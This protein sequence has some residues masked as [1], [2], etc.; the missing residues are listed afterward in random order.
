VIPVNDA[1]HPPSVLSNREDVARWFDDSEGLVLGLDFD[2]TLAPIVDDPTESAIT[3]RARELLGK[4]AAH[5]R[6]LVAVVSGRELDDLV[7]RVGIEGPVYAGNHGLELRV[8][9]ETL[10]HPEAARQQATIQQLVEEL[11]ERLED[12]PGSDV[13]DKGL[14]ATVHYRQ[15]SDAADDVVSTV[16][17]LV[18][19]AE[20]DV[21]VSSGKEIRE[22]R[23]SVE[24][25]KGAAMQLL[26]D[27]APDGY[28]S[29]YVGDDTTDEDAFRAVQ[30]DGVGIR[31]GSRTDE[32]TDAAYQVPN[33]DAVPQLLA[34]I[35]EYADERWEAEESS[36][37]PQRGGWDSDALLDST[38][39]RED[40][41]R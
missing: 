38:F 6:V 22:I 18:D 37:T 34:W 26:R 24:W 7:D 2:G 3:G 17:T 28:Q 13:E 36:D 15:G 9:E 16:E 20:T 8:G 1:T 23:P 4:L 33:Q 10:V 30:P 41:V 5:P 14:S 35:A 27:R 12:V 19:E 32:A 29:L 25:D 31:V 40:E 11:R 21:R 39:V